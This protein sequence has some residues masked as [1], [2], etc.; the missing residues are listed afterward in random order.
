MHNPH[1]YEEANM[2]TSDLNATVEIKSSYGVV[3]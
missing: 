1:P 2:G 3:P